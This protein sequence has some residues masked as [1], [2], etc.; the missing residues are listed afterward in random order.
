MIDVYDSAVDHRGVYGCA[1][2]RDDDTAYFY[3][4]DMTEG[5]HRI[6][7]AFDVYPVTTM[8][9]DISVTVRF[10]SLDDMAG[11]LIDGE[12][13]VVY[14]LGDG[15]APQG[16]WATEADRARFAPN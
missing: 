12:V 10:S 2:E 5:E 8:P 16:R 11:L 9:A 6:I 4:M 1:F 15:T 3:L 13:L 14:D 7:S